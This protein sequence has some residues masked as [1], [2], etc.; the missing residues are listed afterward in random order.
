MDNQIQGLQIRLDEPPPKT[1]T[2]PDGSRVEKGQPLPLVFHRRDAQRTEIFE[3]ARGSPA[4][5]HGRRP[6]QRHAAHHRGASQI[7]HRQLFIRRRAV[8]R[9]TP[10]R[11]TSGIWRMWW[12]SFGPNVSW[13]VWTWTCA[14]IHRY[15]G[16]RARSRSICMPL[17]EDYRAFIWPV[18][19][20]GIDDFLLFESS[21]K[22]IS[23]GQHE[24]ILEDMPV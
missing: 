10:A 11:G 8:H 16:H 14:P 23:T 22:N 6:P 12:S 21:S 15:S 7:R 1:V 24:R 4:A 13:N 5:I 3:T 20:K 19:Q 17:C 2:L 18:E 9:V